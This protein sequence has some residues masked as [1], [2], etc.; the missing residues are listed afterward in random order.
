M[1]QKLAN[2]HPP[3]GRALCS[4]PAAAEAGGL[5]LQRFVVAVSQ[6]LRSIWAC[7][8]PSWSCYAVA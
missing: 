7:S 3:P 8:W 2:L 4:S 6:G 1:I 5:P